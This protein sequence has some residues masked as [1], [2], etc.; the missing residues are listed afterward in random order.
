[1][2]GV[3]VELGAADLDPVRDGVVTGQAVDPFTGMPHWMLGNA[4]TVV[5]AK[6]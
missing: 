2:E 5:R 1:M 4:S 3:A 6:K